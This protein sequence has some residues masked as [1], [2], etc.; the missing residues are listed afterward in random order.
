MWKI[1]KFYKFYFIDL[2]EGTH[3]A[4]ASS[5][6]FKMTAAAILDFEKNGYSWRLA[7]LISRGFE[8]SKTVLILNKCFF[9]RG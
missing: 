5:P 2:R 4:I 6:S 8:D 9:Q 7:D 3:D 1:K